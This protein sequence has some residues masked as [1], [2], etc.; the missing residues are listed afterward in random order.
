MLAQVLVNE[1]NVTPFWMS[2]SD[3][4]TKFI[5]ESEKLLKILFLMTTEQSPS[6][7]IIDE[8]DSIGRKRSSGESEIERRIK[9][10]FL[11]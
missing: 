11:K 1:L 10:E 3:I 5:G 7:I 6:I 4:T 2:L 8:I 9:T